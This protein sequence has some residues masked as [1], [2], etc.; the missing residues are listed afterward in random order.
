MNMNPI[1]EFEMTSGDIY[2][3]ELGNST[4]V[5]TTERPS[6]ASSFWDSP[7]AARD[8]LNMIIKRQYE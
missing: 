7:T 5:S 2:V 1:N 3:D 4:E 6:Q 8:A